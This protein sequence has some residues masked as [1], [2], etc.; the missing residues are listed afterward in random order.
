MTREKDSA[1][2]K[3]WNRKRKR[4][5]VKNLGRGKTPKKRQKKQLFKSIFG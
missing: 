1:I 5:T 4:N 2:D 3:S